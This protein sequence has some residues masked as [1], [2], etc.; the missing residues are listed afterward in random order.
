[1]AGQPKFDATMRFVV[2]YGKDSFLL[3][4]YASDF[5][6]ILQ[7]AFGDVDRVTFDGENVDLAAVL[8][9]LRTYDLLMRHKLVVVDHADSFL[10]AKDSGASSTR[11]SLERYAESPVD[12]ATLLLR[13]PTWRK[14]NLDKAVNKVGLVYKLQE[15]SEH[16]S[17][18]WCIG[19]CGKEHGATL[20]SK[21]AQLLVQRIGTNLTR[22]DGELAKLAAKVAPETTV[23]YEDVVELVGMSREE[24]AWEIQSVVLSG[25][26]SAVLTKLGELIDIS[27]QPRELLVWSI[28]DLSRRLAAASA[29][30]ASGTASGEIRRALKLFGTSGDRIIAISK[31]HTPS[32]FANLFTDTVAMDAK[33]RSGN[34]DTRRGV[35]LLALQV[36]TKIS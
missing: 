27:R 12:S 11:K 25:N 15:L 1:M 31:R 10:A 16:D 7:D 29:M 28:V 13:A 9:E 23:S 32:D 8:D 5:E 36:C 20:D 26:S 19:R 21:A 6:S 33:M 35:E 24:Q 4:R 14:G 3:S 17:V 2:L 18:R 34:L 30:H 22:L